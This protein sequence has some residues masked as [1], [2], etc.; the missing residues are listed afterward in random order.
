MAGI[1][2]RLPRRLRVAAIGGG[3]PTHMTRRVAASIAVGLHRVLSLPATMPLDRI[4]AELNTFRPNFLNAYPS[5]AVL[6]AGEQEAGRLRIALQGMSTSSELRTPEMTERLRSAFGVAPVDLYGTTEGLWGT[7]CEEG[8]G[9][10]LFEDLTV[11]EN[12][13]G[14]GRPVPDGERGAHL[15][16]TSLFNRVQ[17]L[18]RFELSDVVTLDPDPCRCGRTLRRVRAI[19]GR[20]DD[21]L[22]LPGGDGRRVAVLPAQFAVVTADRDV[23]EFQVVQTGD[24]LRLRVA[25]RDDARP[26]EAAA[27]L[28]ARLGDRLA[29]LGVRDP[30]IEVETCRALERPPAGKLRLVVADGP[31]A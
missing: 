3:A 28:C 24:A 17:P 13:G 25:L 26:D 21:V 10:H 16:V 1:V 7:S 5:L 9:V 30:R 27:R 11:V 4:V 22:T 18:I 23:R 6:L 8:G 15:L 20:A 14:N 2:P 19:D 31:D 12:V 29:A